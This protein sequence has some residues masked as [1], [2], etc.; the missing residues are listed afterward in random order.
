MAPRTAAEEQLAAIWAQL[1]RVER[2][3]LQDDFFALGGH[4]LLATQVLSRVREAFGVEVP[5]PAFFTAPTVAG[6][7]GHLAGE[8][9]R[10]SDALPLVPLDRAGALPVSFAQ[11]RLWF[12]DQLTPGSPMYNIAEAIRLQGPLDVALLV[13][14]LNRLVERHEALRTNFAA[15]AAG[16]VQVIGGAKRVPLPVTEVSG[17]EAEAERLAREEARKPFDLTTDALLR[18]QVLR[19][20]AEE[21]L[22]LLT[23][24]HIVADGWSMGVLYAELGRIYEALRAGREPELGSL[25]VQYADFAQ[26]QRAYLTGDVLAEQL[27]YW[28]Q[29]LAG[30]PAVL[31]LPTDK[32]RPAVQSFRGARRHRP[33]PPA[34]LAQLDELCREEGA[35]PFMVMLAAYQALLSRYTGQEDLLVGTAIANR[36]RREIEGLIGFF[37][38]MLPMRADLSGRPTFR[39]FLQQVR[40]RALGAFAHQDM[41]LE[42]LVEELQPERDPSR[43]PLVQVAFALQNAPM[44]DLQIEG[45]RVSNLEPAGSDTGTARFDL[46]LTVEESGGVTRAVAEYCTDL[47]DEAT[48]ERL[49]AHFET[50]LA[51]AAADPDRA[52]ADLDLL[53]P[54]EEHLLTA[55]WTDRAVAYDRSRCLHHLVAEH[56]AR[57]PEKPAVICGETTLTYAELH[58][59]AGALGAR[60]Q[61]L[62]VGPDVLVAL[63]LD[64]SAEAVVAMLGVLRAG[65]AFVPVDPTYPADRIAFMLTDSAAPV[66]LTTSDRLPALPVGGAQVLCLD[67]FDW[68]L[69]AEPQELAQPEDLAYVIYTSG[70]TGRPKGVL[71]ER[72]G[73]ANLAAGVAVALGVVPDDRVLQFAS[74]SF[75]AS[76]FE[77]T[78]ALWFGA[79]LCIPTGEAR[80][81]GPA[82]LRFLQEQAITVATVSP[83]ALAAMPATDLPAL[84]MVISAGDAVSADV[85][86]RWAP[87]RRFVNAYGPTETTVWGTVGD[88]E[89]GARVTIGR[90]A[91]NKRLYVLDQHGGLVPVGVAGELYIG[92][93][94]L[95]RGYLNRPELTNERFLET[96]FGRLYRTGD[97]VRRLPDGTLEFLGR[98]DFQVKIRGFRIELGEVQAAVL[99]HPTVGDAI[100]IAR[101]DGPGGKR[102]VAYVTPA[103]ED[104]RPEPAALREFLKERLPDYMVP[105]A[106]LVLDALPLTPNGKVD[107]KALPAPEREE[108]SSS[109]A[110]RTPAEER[111]AAL[112]CA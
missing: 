66:I 92:A 70:S 5:L 82:M 69:T 93:P 14:S 10:Q 22:L 17:G 20:G 47:F 32:P 56:A 1:L 27:G 24:H 103:G 29:E 21:H 39:Q 35:T 91:A 28:Q 34:L 63:C 11:A 58:R 31:E 43:S 84:R 19:L 100:V 99:A 101:E 41:P 68:S 72:H 4:S 78:Q 98:T 6:L 94:D 97:L 62:G 112:W 46:V 7:A 108:P 77:A 73:W 18:A 75:D 33:L 42:R 109:V 9:T 49:L 81:P 53:T 30:A 37:V 76:V 79:T 13:E 51:S 106:I 90:P 26:W 45:V 16:P 23:I 3:G 74:L 83:A 61:A 2:V 54:A 95:A 48:V 89:P 87:G 88:L 36:N 96:R 102:L 12:F 8:A 67:A 57:M 110:P 64:R 105:S 25:P 59:R 15:T 80:M 55:E 52:V 50:L 65:G 40:R 86:T 111:M 71:I 107:R 104:G 60:L 44:D 85:V 38:N